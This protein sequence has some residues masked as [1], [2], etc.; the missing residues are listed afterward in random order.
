MRA[1]QFSSAE[2]TSQL[3]RSSLVGLAIRANC[4]PGLSPGNDDPAALESDER[5]PRRAR[6][7]E[8]LGQSTV[9]TRGEDLEE[10]PILVASR[11]VRD[12]KSNVSRIVNALNGHG[13]AQRVDSFGSSF[14]T[15]VPSLISFAVSP[16]FGHSEGGRSLPVAVSYAFEAA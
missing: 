16:I 7:Y 14:F 4:S 11:R 13:E 9:W 10:I 2:E 15:S 12:R 5:S 8:D 1:G 6:C 3:F